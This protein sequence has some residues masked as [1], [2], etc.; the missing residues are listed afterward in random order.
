MG[1][2]IEIAIL[3][4]ESEGKLCSGTREKLG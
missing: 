2:A 4:V 3:I 1:H